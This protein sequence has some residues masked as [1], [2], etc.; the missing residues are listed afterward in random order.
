MCCQKVTVLGGSFDQPGYFIEFFVCFPITIK[1][2]TPESCRILIEWNLALPSLP[3]IFPSSTDVQWFFPPFL[4]GF[5]RWL[6]LFNTCLISVIFP[7]T[8]VLF[9]CFPL[10]LCHSSPMLR[11]LKI[12]FSSSSS[13]P[14]SC[15]AVAFAHFFFKISSTQ[16]SMLP[17]LVNQLKSTNLDCACITFQEFISWPGLCR[18]HTGTVLFL[19]LVF[20]FFIIFRGFR[21]L[22]WTCGICRLG[23][24]VAFTGLLVFFFVMSFTLCMETFLGSF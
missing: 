4:V 10:E 16:T 22:V 15:A 14:E 23:G 13:N 9:F 20:R 3:F 5:T 2:L 21:G 8:S 24:L 1:E 12:K 17:W 7:H 6:I 18:G 11:F 19:V